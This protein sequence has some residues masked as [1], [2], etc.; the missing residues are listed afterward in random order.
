MKEHTVVISS[1]V[2]IFHRFLL[3]GYVRFCQSCLQ[4]SESQGR[5]SRAKAFSDLDDH[6]NMA[7]NKKIVL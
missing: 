6:G 7:K 2:I 3:S 5:L 1:G 4:I